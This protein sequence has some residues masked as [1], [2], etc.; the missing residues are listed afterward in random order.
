MFETFHH[1][2][3]AEIVPYYVEE[4][5]SEYDN[6]SDINVYLKWLNPQG[7]WIFVPTPVSNQWDDALV[8]FYTPFMDLTDYQK[9]HTTSIKKDNFMVILKDVFKC[10][11]DI[12]YSTKANME[13][14]YLIEKTELTTI[15]TPEIKAL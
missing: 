1:I 9:D 6:I 3:D 10:S 12:I 2:P 5:Y 13:K 7:S 4:W 11:E 8:E 14:K 15:S